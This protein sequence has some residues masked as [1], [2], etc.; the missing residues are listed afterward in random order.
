[1]EWWNSGMTVN[2]KI[3][4]DGR[5]PQILKDRMTENRPKS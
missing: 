4:E 5:S 2:R 3:W 1:M